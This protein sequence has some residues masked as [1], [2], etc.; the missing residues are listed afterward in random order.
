MARKKKLTAEEVR[1]T[2]ERII[3]EIFEKLSP[4]GWLR[5]I[6]RLDKDPNSFMSI[7]EHKYKEKVR[8]LEATLLDRR[9]GLVLTERQ[10]RQSNPKT[11]KRNIA[12]RD[13][14]NQHGRLWRWDI[15]EK[16]AMTQPELVPKEYRLA[17]GQRHSKTQTRELQQWLHS[18]TAPSRRKRT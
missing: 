5:L 17:P 13:F 8:A 10:G 4:A 14:W 16:L 15:V 1:V 12:I 3:D 2:D 18:I 6:S 9:L 7:R 11:T